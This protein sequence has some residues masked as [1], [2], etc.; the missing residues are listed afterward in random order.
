MRTSFIAVC[1]AALFAGPAICRAAEPSSRASAL[2]PAHEWEYL[3]KTIRTEGLEK[4]RAVTI[5]KNM[6]PMLDGYF[7]EKSGVPFSKARWVFPLKY[8]V[9]NIEKYYVA[10]RFD[11]FSKARNN[12]HPASDIFIR[13][14]DQDS[15]D[16]KTGRP[17]PVLSMSCGV[18]V[19]TND[20]WEHG[21]ALRGGKYVWIYDPVTKGL[22]YYAHMSAVL[23][24]VGD[25]VKPGAEIGAVGRTGKNAYAKR[26]RTHLHIMYLHYPENGRPYPQ[27]LYQ[28]LQA[29]RL[30]K[31]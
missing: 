10:N 18:V 20:E 24:S 31:N 9:K 6:R 22:F 14:R 5:M 26:S 2:T 7:R 30:I 27:R 21:D 11:F 28:D 16:D 12:D 23:V 3:E 25:I 17:V 8:G 19:S 29:A 13:D 4:K 1:V 15:I